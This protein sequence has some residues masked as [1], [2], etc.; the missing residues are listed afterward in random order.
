MAFVKSMLTWLNANSVLQYAHYN[1]N[2]VLYDIK[3]KV[4]FIVR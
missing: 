4:T 1:W 2:T 3:V